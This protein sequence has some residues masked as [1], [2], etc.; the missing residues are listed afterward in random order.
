MFILVADRASRRLTMY[1]RYSLYTLYSTRTVVQ[2]VARESINFLAKTYKADADIRGLRLNVVF[3]WIK[4]IIVCIFATTDGSSDATKVAFWTLDK[5]NKTLHT[6]AG[7]NGGRAPGLPPT[8][9][10]HQTPQFL[11]NDNV[12]L[13]ILIEDFEINENWLNTGRVSAN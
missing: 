12:S 6:R 9:A 1:E 5:K 2:T 7:F 13:V 8:G 3:W 11:A 4:L 10:S